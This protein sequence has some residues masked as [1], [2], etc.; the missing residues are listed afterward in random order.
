MDKIQNFGKSIWHSI[1]IVSLGSLSKRDL[2]LLI[3]KS[4]LDA[5]LIEN[6]PA[7]IAENL[8]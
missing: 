2:E 8:K 6:H 4:A 3:M 5:D 1:R 7:F